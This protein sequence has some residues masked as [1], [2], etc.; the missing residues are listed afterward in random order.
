MPD[1]P[2][3]PPPIVRA[4]QFGWEKHTEIHVP[5]LAIF[6]F[7]EADDTPTVEQANA[8]EAGLPSARVVRLPNA[9][10]FVFRSNEADVPREMNAFLAK[11]P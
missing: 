8:F 5:I 1:M 10:H 4:I 3:P 6:A 9:N 7:H 2:P 11:P